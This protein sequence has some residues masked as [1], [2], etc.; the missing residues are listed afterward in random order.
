MAF[1]TEADS[2]PPLKEQ[3]WEKAYSLNQFAFFFNQNLVTIYEMALVS[4]L[5]YLPLL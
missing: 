1:H 3:Q 4:I 5:L 2:V